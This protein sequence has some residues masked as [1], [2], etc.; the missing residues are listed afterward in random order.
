[1]KRRVQFGM[2]IEKKRELQIYLDKSNIVHAKFE[3]ITD[4]YFFQKKPIGKGGFGEVY[5]CQHIKTG[6]LRAVKHIELKR[7]LK[8]VSKKGNHC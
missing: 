3:E 5:A 8:A 7:S 2:E 4:H 1:M 6:E